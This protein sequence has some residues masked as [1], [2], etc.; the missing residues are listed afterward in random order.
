MTARTI[1]HRVFVRAA[2]RLNA[3]PVRKLK[4]LSNGRRDEGC[5]FDSWQEMEA[6]NKIFGGY[7]WADV[8][9]EKER[10]QVRILVLLLAA[11]VA[12]SGGL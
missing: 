10:D 1:D 12:E 7:T 4:Y 5:C 6:F 8:A 3:M 11:C 2:R 9:T